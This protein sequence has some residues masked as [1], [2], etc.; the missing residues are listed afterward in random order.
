MNEAHSSECPRPISNAS[1]DDFIARW[2]EAFGED[3]SRVDASARAIQLLELC[4]LTRPAAPSAD[5]ASEAP[6]SS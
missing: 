5:G 3:V 4:R 6:A 2:K 1:L